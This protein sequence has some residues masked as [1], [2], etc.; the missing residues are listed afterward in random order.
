MSIQRISTVLALTLATAAA[1]GDDGGGGNE[2]EVITTITL[3]VTPVG[4]GAAI[5][6]GIDDPDGDGG[7]APVLTPLVLAPGSYTATVR[8][9]NKLEDPPEEIT[10]EVRDE[11]VEHQV[12]FTGTAVDGPASDHP[13]APLTHA[14]DDVDANGLPIGLSNTLTAAAG[15][16]QLTVTLRHLPPVNDAAVK[17]AT[18]AADVRAGGLDAIGGSTDATMTIDATVR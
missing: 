9:Q 13:G 8:F 10:D 1:C 6:A 4:G 12:F 15:T 11:G 5:T 7:A 2:N 16:G 14:Y 3:S 17:G 18:T